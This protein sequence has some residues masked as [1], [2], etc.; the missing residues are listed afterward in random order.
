MTPT[1]P[2]TREKIRNHFH[3]HWWQYMLLIIGSV[4]LWNLLYTTTHYR[5][6]EHLKVEWYYGGPYLPQTQQLA[7]E[8]IADIHEQIFPEMEEVTFTS[9]GL[10]QNYGPMQ[11]TVW[12]STGQGD[13]YMLTEDN[14]KQQASTGAFLDLQPYVENG[15]LNVQGIDLSKGYVKH[16][17]TGEKALYGIPAST[18]EGM[19]EYGIFTEKTFLSVLANGGN[20]EN[21]LKLVSYLLEHM[22]KDLPQ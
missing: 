22:Q 12:M 17:D 16:A 18:L 1:F 11:L 21:T 7:D 5:S 20:T 14:F 15:T 2:I 9:V 8:L 19:Q 10:D 4:F 13:L 6:P 3:Y